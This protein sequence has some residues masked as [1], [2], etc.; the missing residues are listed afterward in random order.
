MSAAS[1][2]DVEARPADVT[3][4]R[5]VVCAAAAAVA[6]ASATAAHASWSVGLLLAWDAAALAFL[7]LVWPA[8]GTK[9]A[10]ATARR[11]GSEE[12]SHR[13]TEA[14]LVSASVASLA[15]VAFTLAQAG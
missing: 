3:A 15:A 4:R 8:I 11:A 13:A 7:A 12:G 1:S 14:V 6:L 9:D 10:A 2:G 5:I